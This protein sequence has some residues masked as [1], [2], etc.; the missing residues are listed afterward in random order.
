MLSLIDIVA[1]LMG[2]A[3]LFRWIRK[4]TRSP[5]PVW[6]PGYGMMA[7][8][9]PFLVVPQRPLS[10]SLTI[11]ASILAVTLGTAGGLAYARHRR[12]RALLPR[13]GAAPLGL[14]SPAVDREACR[15]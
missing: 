9:L 6:P 11:G 8:M 7:L 12:R 2:V 4:D 3:V 14:A 5:R 13:P 1:V 15:A 10:W